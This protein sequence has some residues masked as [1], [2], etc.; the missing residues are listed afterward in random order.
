M[1]RVSY[2]LLILAGSM[3]IL[4][5]CK[6][7][8][9]VGPQ[10]PETA[11][12]I[13]EETIN[14]IEVDKGQIG[15]VADVRKLA[16]LG[17]NPATVK[18]EFTGNVSEHSTTVLVNE[19]TNTATF[20]IPAEQLNESIVN[21]FKDGVSAK[22]IVYDDKNNELESQNEE[23]IS[24]DF[25]GRFLKIETT[26]QRVLPPL[27]FNPKV[28]QYIQ[29]NLEN[30]EVFDVQLIQ[31]NYAPIVLY[32]VN[33]GNG[34]GE[35]QKYYFTKLDNDS[36][37][38]IKV[39]LTN[40]YLEMSQYH[41]LYQNPGT[42]DLNKLEDKNKFILHQCED[43]WVKIRPYM[44]SSYLK[45]K[46]SGEWTQLTTAENAPD[47][48]DLKF[49]ILSANIKWQL[50]SMGTEYSAPV[51]P[52]AKM[53][54]AVQATLKNCSG[55]TLTETIGKEKSI[56][57]SASFGWEESLEF[58]S[59]HTVGAS[60][61]AGAS[62]T[63]SFFGQEATASVEA[64]AS[65]EYQASIT[66]ARKQ[67]G[68]IDS[69]KTDVFFRNREVVLQPYSAIETYDAIQVIEN[70]KLPFVQKFKVRGVDSKTQLPLSGDEIVSQMLA[71]YFKG[72]VSNVGNDYV[73]FTIKGTL[74]LDK[75]Y[76]TETNVKDI[77][78]AC[79]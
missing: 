44:Y 61:T 42:T 15:I 49:R 6:K 11:G 65:Y 24:I 7:D 68:N 33:E 9:P 78:G 51:I 19:F 39:E 47:E 23:N 18:F 64:T 34:D 52:P 14:S 8:D 72:V 3:L 20:K 13:S 46:V 70:I 56:S 5:G 60:V 45:E 40:S 28:P 22:I 67:Q 29:S 1:K 26:K 37:F 32:T 63:G 66:S 69:T 2:F 27:K 12:S 59:S 41:Y 62:V 17:Y 77:E 73:E 4:S 57:S 76:K 55:A 53:E 16:V 79:D 74:T 71:N 48:P 21:T 10:E 75:M 54:F 31:T 35:H 58:Y 38:A 36:T 43:G 25:S 50:E 30:G